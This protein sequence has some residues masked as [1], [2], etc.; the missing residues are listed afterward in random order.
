MKTMFIELG[1][2]LEAMLG[3]HLSIVFALVI[4]LY[5]SLMMI[6]TSIELM[7]WFAVII[8]LVLHFLPLAFAFKWTEGELISILVSAGIWGKA[9]FAVCSFALFFVLGQLLTVFGFV[10]VGLLGYGPALL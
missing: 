6:P 4:S 1:K 5:A 10:P 2:E 7:G 9:I 8:G 3:V